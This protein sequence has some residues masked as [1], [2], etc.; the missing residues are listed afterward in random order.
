MAVVVDVAAVVDTMAV[1]TDVA[2]V[3]LQR[4]CCQLRC[5]H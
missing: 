4:Y 2:V 3:V 5:C 1:D